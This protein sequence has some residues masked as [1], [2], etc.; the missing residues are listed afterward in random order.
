MAENTTNENTA[1]EE[2]TANEATTNQEVPTNTEAP[3]NNEGTTNEGEAL[4]EGGIKALHAERKARAEAEKRATEMAKR[5]EEYEAAQRT[6]AENLAHE[7]DKALA[8]LEAERKARADAERAVI[9]REVVAE[10]GLPVELAGRIQGDDREAMLEDARVFAAIAKA[11]EPSRPAP[12]GAV[13]NG[14]NA[15]LSTSELFSNAIKGVL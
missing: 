5:I 1:N 14:N 12:I 11:N 4:G 10:M 7:R 8:E 2:G 13:G 3:P 9:A 6:E 15:P